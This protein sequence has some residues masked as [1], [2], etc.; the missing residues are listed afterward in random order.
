MTVNMAAAPKL[1][2]KGQKETQF[3]LLNSLLCI[4]IM[5]RC[6]GLSTIHCF[7][8]VLCDK[9]ESIKITILECLKI[10]FA[11][12]PLLKRRVPQD[13]FCKVI[14]ILSKIETPTLW[15][16]R[17]A[18]KTAKELK[19]PSGPRDTDQNMGNIDFG[20]LQNHLTRKTNLKYLIS[21]EQ[22]LSNSYSIGP[23]MLKCFRKC[24]TSLKIGS[25][26]Y[27]LP[28]EAPHRPPFSNLLSLNDP[29][30]IFHILLSPN[31]PHFQNALSLND[32]SEW[33]HFKK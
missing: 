18:F 3:P 1:W 14:L 9:A 22:F 5:Q 21:V 8:L 29:L 28:G 31:D 15:K 20:V 26:G 2:H 10:S 33:P 17:H 27:R 4:D 25:C 7:I 19:K 32:L 24:I 11:L 16:V 6:Q 13:P 23:S 12:W 30:F